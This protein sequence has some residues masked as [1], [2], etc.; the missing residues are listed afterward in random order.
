M[1]LEYLFWLVVLSAGNAELL[2]TA[3]NRIHSRPLPPVLL[4]EIRHLHD[5]LIPLFPSWLI[6]VPGL[7]APGVLRRPVPIRDVWTALP[8]P[9]QAWCV[10]CLA[11]FAGLCFGIARYWL[12]RTPRAQT[13]FES[14]T[15]DIARALGRRPVGDGPFQS[16]VR[17]PF[18]QCF[19]L[20]VT[21]RTFELDRLPPRW[22]GLSILHLSDL[23]F[24]GTIDRSWFER[25][26]EEALTLDFDM[27][28][29]TGDII[30]RE[31]CLDWLPVTLGRL[32]APQG[33]WF[34]L[35]NHDWHIDEQR[36]RDAMRGLGWTDL[37]GTLHVLD[38]AGQRIVLGGS[39][40]PWMGKHPPFHAAP[41]DAFRL[42]LSHSPDNF[43]WA[44]RQ[45]VDLM[46]SG[47]N[48]GGQVVLPGIGPVFSPS[49]HGVRYAGGVFQSGPTL[50]FVNRGLSGR[51]PL[52]VGARPEISRLI[53]RTGSK[54]P[55]RSA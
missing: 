28:V 38:M 23:H 41:E 32:H 14:R 3:V 7:F 12:Q 46:L 42:L 8:L 30:D 50:M 33:C 48:H 16:L 27:V 9:L 43:A 45:R 1:L 22:D 20:E 55:A 15:L 19:Q 4:R 11:G 35:G 26:I 10:M 31:E 13:A 52:R 36:V 40:R 49:L 21:T 47:H 44:R 54:P 34:I 5:L 24:L 39:E 17:L 29:C 6:V 37:A 2:I 18:N 51:H 53:L 25:V